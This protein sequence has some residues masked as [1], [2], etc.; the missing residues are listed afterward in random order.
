MYMCKHLH[1]LSM[2]VPCLELLEGEGL[3]QVFKRIAKD[4]TER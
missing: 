3:S 4:M 2:G 1:I